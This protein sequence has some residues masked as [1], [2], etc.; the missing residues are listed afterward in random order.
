MSMIQNIPAALSAILALVLVLTVITNIIV[1]VIK[2]LTGGAVPC[3]IVAVAVALIVTLIAFF[4]Y[5]SL[6]GIAVVWYM[7]AGAVIVGLFVS[8]AA[9][10]GYDKFKEAIEQITKK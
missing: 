10:F 4:A 7:V 3:N 1:A 8:Y 2:A 5:C 6:K 9:M